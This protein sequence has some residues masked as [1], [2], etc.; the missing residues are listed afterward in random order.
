MLAALRVLDAQVEREMLAEVVEGLFRAECDRCNARSA[1]IGGSRPVAIL[2][3]MRDG[4]HIRSREQGIA[5]ICPE[6]ASA[7]PMQPPP[8][9]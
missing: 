5:S 1:E 2:R 9:P 4:W 6:C 8:K 7:S 3:L